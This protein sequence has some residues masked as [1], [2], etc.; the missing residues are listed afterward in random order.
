M[1]R[2]GERDIRGA[3]TALR[4]RLTPP[5]MAAALKFVHLVRTQVPAEL[6]QASLFGS[7]A[8]GD[9]RPDSDLDVLLVFGWLTEDREPQ[10]TMAEQLAERVADET[11]VPVTTWSVSLVDLEMGRRTPMLVDALHDSLP[12]WWRGEPLPVVPF[13]PLDALW[14]TERLLARVAE[15]G[16]E[17]AFHLHRG[18][19]HRA[20]RRARDDLVRLC[21][22]GLLLRGCTRPRRADAVRA[23]GADE[24]SGI[25]GDGVQAAVLAWAATSFGPDGKQEDV[26][27]RPPPGGLAAVARVIERFRRRVV[28]DARALHDRVHRRPGTGGRPRHRT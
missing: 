1:S 28:A 25:P 6:V 17:F 27:L 21:T 20:A 7:R 24:R 18:D 2:A 14:C 22:A 13:T 3:G 19:G 4:R 26:A 11:G 16:E 9:A 8:R 10:A 15:G 23:F 12:L 5:E